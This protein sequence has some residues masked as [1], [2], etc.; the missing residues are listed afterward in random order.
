MEYASIELY[1]SIVTAINGLGLPTFSQSQTLPKK[2]PACRV[3]INSGTD[4]ST[5]KNAREYTYAFQIDVVTSQNNLVQGMRYA[6]QIRDLLRTISV[7]GYVVTLQGSPQVSH[8]VE[9]GTDEIINRQ[10]LRASY[11]IIEETAF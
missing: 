5:F 3:S 1:E 6:C 4:T 11:E 8:L 2:L 10:M 7:D 9:T